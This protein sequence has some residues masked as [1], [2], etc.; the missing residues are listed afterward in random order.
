M[1][2]ES[3]PNHEEGRIRVQFDFTPDELQELKELQR[4]TGAPTRNALMKSALNA[5]RWLCEKSRRHTDLNV[6]IEDLRAILHVK[7]NNSDIPLAK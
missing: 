4:L 5:Y 2:K 1:K 6:P 3:S 7:K